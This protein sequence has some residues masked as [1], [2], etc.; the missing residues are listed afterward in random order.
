[1][2]AAA[3]CYSGISV[4]SGARPGYPPAIF[5]PAHELPLHCGS[6]RT[7][8]SPT[9]WQPGWAPPIN[10][11]TIFMLSMVIDRKIVGHH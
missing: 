4:F 2:A 11:S 1:M 10:Q 6:D 9:Q 3:F 8:H 5:L 7:E